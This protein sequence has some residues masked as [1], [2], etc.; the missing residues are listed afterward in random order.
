MNNQYYKNISLNILVN[1]DEILVKCKDTN[2]F[3]FFLPVSSI[4]KFILI[5]V[6]VGREHKYNQP[7]IIYFNF[8]PCFYSPLFHI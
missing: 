5:T 7:K 8:Y 1:T 3:C 6:G 2:V 4:K